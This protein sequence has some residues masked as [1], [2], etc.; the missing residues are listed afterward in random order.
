MGF[1]AKRKTQ[2]LY[3]AILNRH[4]LPYRHH[5]SPHRQK[6]V[7]SK[8]MPQ[9]SGAIPVS[10]ASTSAPAVMEALR[11]KIQQLEKK[12]AATQQQVEEMQR[13]FDRQEAD[14]KI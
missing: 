6:H 9:L 4:Y 3:S 2:K 14:R 7:H 11:N 13:R 12:E 1:G 10:N 8:A 5:S